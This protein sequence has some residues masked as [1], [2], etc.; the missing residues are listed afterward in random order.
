MKIEKKVWPKY[1]QKILDGRKNFEVRLADWKCQEGDVL[2][3]REWNSDTKEYTGRVLEK[4]VKYVVKT[5]DL[6]FWS[7]EEVEKHGFMVLGL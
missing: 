5:K 1:F 6:Q 4:E 3:L 2:V 7:P